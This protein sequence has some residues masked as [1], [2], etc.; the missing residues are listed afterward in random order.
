MSF[1]PESFGTAPQPFALGYLFL[2]SLV[3]SFHFHSGV[4]LVAINL[5]G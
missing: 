1:G 4:G 2:A 5:L 3:R